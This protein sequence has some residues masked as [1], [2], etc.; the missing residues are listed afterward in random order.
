MGRHTEASLW[1]FNL[2]CNLICI[3]NIIRIVLQGL[4]ISVSVI[5]GNLFEALHILTMGSG[6]EAVLTLTRVGCGV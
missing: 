4:G 3:A 1:Y 5:Q 6:D 2:H